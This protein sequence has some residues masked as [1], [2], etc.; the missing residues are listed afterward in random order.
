M[1]CQTEKKP[2]K[3]NRISATPGQ[4]SQPEVR[5]MDGNFPRE[6]RAAALTA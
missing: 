3:K 2:I 5:A 6:I 1:Y 4:T